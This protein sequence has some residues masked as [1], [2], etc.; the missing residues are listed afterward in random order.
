MKFFKVYKNINVVFRRKTFVFLC[1][2]LSDSSYKVIGYSDV[3][4]CSMKVR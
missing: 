3:Q 2:M 4:N 1:L